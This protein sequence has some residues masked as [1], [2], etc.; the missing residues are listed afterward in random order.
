MQFA[1]FFRGYLAV[2]TTAAVSNCDFSKKLLSFDII[3]WSLNDY[4][5]R[6]LI[7]HLIND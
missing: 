4:L 1:E 5:M 2:I 7:I 6:K 3:C